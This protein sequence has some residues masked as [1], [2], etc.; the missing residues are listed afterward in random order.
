MGKK[1][2]RMFLLSLKSRGCLN[3]LGYIRD[4]GE[5]RSDVQPDASGNLAEFT[6]SLGP[7]S[8]PVLNLDPDQSWRIFQS[9]NL[10]WTEHAGESM[11]NALLVSQL[12]AKHF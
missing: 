10:C 3:N 2:G 6:T 11:L 1:K 8:A 5:E 4:K 9:R 7:S 12:A